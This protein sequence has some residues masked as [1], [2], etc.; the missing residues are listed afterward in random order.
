MEHSTVNGAIESPIAFVRRCA[1]CGQGI[2]IVI[3]IWFRAI[4]FTFGHSLGIKGFRSMDLD[5]WIR[6]IGLSSLSYRVVG[7]WVPGY[8]AV[9][10]LVA[11]YWLLEDGLVGSGL[12][13]GFDF[14][15][16]LR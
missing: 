7:Y 11:D 9:G 13:L 8:S 3:Q 10:F 5:I 15:L 2:Q 4:G 12:G 14:G 16:G 6:V 1:R